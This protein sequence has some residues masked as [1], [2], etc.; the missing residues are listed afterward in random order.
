MSATAKKKVALTVG[1][2]EFNFEVG[3]GE[4]TQFQNEFLPNNKVAPSENFLTRCVKPDQ[5]DALADIL[6]QGYAVELAQLVAG[7]FKPEIKIEVKK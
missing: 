6:D 1:E 7:E 4:F 3:I 2:N 5:R